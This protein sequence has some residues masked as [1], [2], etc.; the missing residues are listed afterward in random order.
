ME[1]TPQYPQFI[2]WKIE[3]KALYNW[4]T[5]NLRCLCPQ[6]RNYLGLWK[7]N[8]NRISVKNEVR[9]QMSALQFQKH[10]VSY[11]SPHTL[12]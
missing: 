1:S 10:Y 5:K 4:T 12:P 8:C 3:I 6:Q 7:L 11:I 2:N 9:L